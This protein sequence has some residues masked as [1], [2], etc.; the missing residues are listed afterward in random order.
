MSSRP[1]VRGCR[2]A[3]PE[4]FQGAA[5]L[6]LVRHQLATLE[7]RLVTWDGDVWPGQSARIQIAEDDAGN[8]PHDASMW[9]TRLTLNL[10]ALGPIDAILSMQGDTVQLHLSVG[11]A[12]SAPALRASQH[13]LAGALEQRALSLAGFAIEHV[14]G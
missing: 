9:R 13:D 10:P 12:D 1:R 5:A 2:P 14:A 11:V 7:T 8:A 6:P 3:L 4:A